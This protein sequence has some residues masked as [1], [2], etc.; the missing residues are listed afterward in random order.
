[1]AEC[2][3]STEQVATGH[4][5][6]N[7]MLVPVKIWEIQGTKVRTQ[8]TKVRTQGTK[9]RTHGTKV[10]TQGTKVRTQGTKVGVSMGASWYEMQQQHVTIIRTTTTNHIKTSTAQCSR[11]Y[12]CHM[13][14]SYIG[15]KENG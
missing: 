3:S 7:G 10:R 9:V 14:K 6:C 15:L 4:H 11:Q 1:V 13:C 8:G 12:L 5:V 2:N